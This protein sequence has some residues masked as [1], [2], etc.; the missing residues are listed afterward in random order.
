MHISFSDASDLWKNLTV[1]D[2]TVDGCWSSDLSFILFALWLVLAPAEVC[3]TSFE[4]YYQ[5]WASKWEITNANESKVGRYFLLQQLGTVGLK[6]VKQWYFQKGKRMML[7]L[8]KES[9][10][11]LYIKFNPSIMTPTRTEQQL[12]LL[13]SCPYARQSLTTSPL[14]FDWT[15]W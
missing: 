6:L 10:I 8:S 9:K 4:M 7:S 11:I 1:N 14:L 13:N 12:V 3:H 2:P 15:I 5:L